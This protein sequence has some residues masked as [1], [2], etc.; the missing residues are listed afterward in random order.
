MERTS[1]KDTARHTILQSVSN[2]V[3][4]KIPRRP[5]KLYPPESTMGTTDL[6]PHPQLTLLY[7]LE[8]GDDGYLPFRACVSLKFENEI[9][10]GL[11]R[12]FLPHDN[13]R[14]TKKCTIKRSAFWTD[15]D[16]NLRKFELQ[17]E[18]PT[19]GFTS[20][21]VFPP[22]VRCCLSTENGY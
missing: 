2:N 21:P 22:N 20:H 5:E 19:R 1:C 8:F 13:F 6:S 7:F 4:A 14:W 12:E 16:W 15:Y 18:R 9:P 10:S 17:T 3:P 11:S